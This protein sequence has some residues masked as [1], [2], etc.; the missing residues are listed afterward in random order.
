MVLLERCAAAS[1]ITRPRQTTSRTDDGHRDRVAYDH[2]YE[3]AEAAVVG[4]GPATDALHK[5]TF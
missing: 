1:M 4:A 5:H 3:E 2:V